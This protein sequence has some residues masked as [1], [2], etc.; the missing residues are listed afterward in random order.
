MVITRRELSGDVVELEIHGDLNE[1]TVNELRAALNAEL[2]Q[3]HRLIRLNM[4]AVHSI[5]SAALGEILL[6]QKKALEKHMGTRITKCS[7]DLRKILLAIRL[8]RIVEM[9][10]EAAPSAEH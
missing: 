9:S 1:D 2:V 4:N 8:D 5:I 6:F 10:E 7:D 3:P